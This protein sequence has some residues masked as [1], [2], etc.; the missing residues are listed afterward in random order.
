MKRYFCFYYY[1]GNGLTKF[2]R[3][4]PVFA[5]LGW[6]VYSDEIVFPSFQD[7]S[8]DIGEAH[9][10]KV[11]LRSWYDYLTCFEKNVYIF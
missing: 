1:V 11:C 3:L 5:S 2:D 6:I 8:K 7:A 10:A 9:P 4:S